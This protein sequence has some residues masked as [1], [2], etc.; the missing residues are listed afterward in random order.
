M[1]PINTRG[2]RN[3]EHKTGP[4][5]EDRPPRAAR[6]SQTR[7]TGSVCGGGSV[8]GGSE[9][10]WEGSTERPSQHRAVRGEEDT[11][12]HG[13]GSA[14]SQEQRDC[15]YTWLFITPTQL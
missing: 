2:W 8:K 7:H 15:G 3:S 4:D 10:W 6:R 1:T 9:G 13:R 12:R 5:H 14:V 11:V